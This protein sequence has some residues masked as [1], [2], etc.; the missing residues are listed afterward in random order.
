MDNYLKNKK[1]F[2]QFLINHKIN[3]D[4]LREKTHTC[5]GEPYGTYHIPDNEYNKF[6]MLYKRIIG[7]C[8][9]L[10]VI[11]RHDGKEVGPLIIDIDYWVDGDCKGRKYREDHIESLVKITAKMLNKYFNVKR[12]EV[13]ILVMEKGKPTY[14][15]NKNKYKDGFHL[16][17]PVPLS[18]K[19]RYFL[20]EMIRNKAKK[21]DI[22]GDI[23][24]T[25]EEGYEK[26]FDFS[27]LYDNGLT[28]YGSR[29]KDSQVYELSMIFNSYGER[30]KIT[31]EPDELVILCSLRRYNRD[32]EIFVKDNDKI[33][34]K[35]EEIYEKNHSK[36]DKKKKIDKQKV[37]SEKQLNKNSNDNDNIKKNKLTKK[38]KNTDTELARKLLKIL[39]K[40]RANN[41]HEWLHV[42]WA[43]HNIDIELLDDY[44]EFSQQSTKWENGCCEKIWNNAKNKE[45]GLTIASLHWW[46]QNDNPDEYTKIMRDSINRL[47]LEAETG[48]HDDIAKIVFEL[49]K[50]KYRCTSIQKN[51]WYE[52]QGHK[53]V[54]IDSGYTLAMKLSDEITKEYA[55]MAS[56]YLAQSSAMDG[57]SNETH[58]TKAKN[59]FKIVEKLKNQSFK[60]QIIQA[61]SHRFHEISKNFEELLDSNPNLLGFEN[62]VFDLEHGCFRNGLPDDYISMTTKY[63]YI[64]YDGEQD[65]EIKAINSYFG[66]VMIEEDMRKY[67]L[68]FISSCLDGHSREQKF[69]LWTGIGCHTKDTEILMYDGSKKKV[70][71]IKCNEKLMGDD[72]KP[73]AVKILYTGEQEMYK[74]Y[75]D[76][77]ES[78]IVNKNHRLALRN[79]FETRI[80]S[81][82]DLFDQNIYWVE[83]YEYLENIPIKRSTAFLKKEKAQKY[84][85]KE[86]KRK[87]S[88]IYYNE[89]VP[90]KVADYLNIDENTKNDFVMYNNGIEFN[91]ENDDNYNYYEYAKEHGYQNISEQFLKIKLDNR[92][93]YIAGL[94]DEYG[95]Y[96]KNIKTYILPKEIVS[97]PNVENILRSVGLRIEIND[98]IKLSNGP[99]NKISNKIKK[100]ENKIDFEN[101]DIY[102]E[103]KIIN[104][105][106]VGRD[107][108]YGFE[109]DGDEKYLMG[110]FMATYNSNGKSTTVELVEKTLGEYFGVLPTTVL[111]RKR[112]NASNATPEL[113]D[114]RGKRVLF[115]Q[116]PEH[117]DTVYV[118]LMKNLTGGDWI[119][120]RA[121]YGMPFRYKPQFKLVL[122]CNKLPYV[123]ANDQGTWRRLRVTPWE[124]KFVKDPKNKKEFKMDKTL[125][126]KLKNWKQGFVWLLLNKYYPDYRKNGLEEPSKV[127]QYTDQYKQDQDVYSAYLNENIEITGKNRDKLPVQTIYESFK[128]YIKNSGTGCTAPSRKEFEEYVK[129]LDK[130]NV[131]NGTILGVKQKESLD[132]DEGDDE[133]LKV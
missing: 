81:D 17:C 45:D 52:F 86:I 96:D 26:I 57:H 106:C 30:K 63:N 105:E 112:G 115:I 91:N 29:K 123:P 124:S 14:D 77:G 97:N 99:I 21:K 20:S 55:S 56:L 66:T 68:K 12:S 1:D 19:M 43:L 116:E 64:E 120:A 117:D 18:V 101:N 33:K 102:G 60:G 32:D 46:A 24:Y 47:V 4:D 94:I 90:I 98:N 54:N 22:F 118:G 59:V 5:Y 35:I 16:V 2:D 130:I 27:V 40:R 73:R 110:N 87:E 131:I 76:N 93:E 89:V 103:Y 58:V 129:T 100:E 74:I 83:W 11:E 109:I 37:I 127:T 104:T 9:N 92:I 44:I 42:G 39:N 70:Q 65:E 119:E 53:W 88:Y 69:V 34:E 126:E 3:K 80:Y 67:V 31:Y 132:D 108:F 114:K 72:G 23:P 10:H 38:S 8:K 61:C 125:Q 79:K 107:R 95:N 121:L 122:V 111:T 84:L 41:Y 36:C 28:M 15:K 78:F 6:L 49:Y 71:D 75:L 85:E 62:G 25:D 128:T 7:N 133:N 50:H 13:E 82:I 51:I 113:A 48:T